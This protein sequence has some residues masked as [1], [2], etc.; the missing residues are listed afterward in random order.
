[1]N[2]IVQAI[3]TNGVSAVLLF[4][5]ILNYARKHHEKNKENKLFLAMLS[6]NLMQCVI[7]TITIIIDGKMFSGAISLATILN[8]ALFANN[9]I[10]ALL[11]SLYA[12]AKVSR[13]NKQSG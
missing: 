10:F 3:C 9:I 13:K 6:V 5:L 11:W 12:D 8:A 2:Y 4:S 7:E 1:M